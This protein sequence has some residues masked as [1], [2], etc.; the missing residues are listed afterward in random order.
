MI[1][2]TG[3]LINLTEEERKQ[4]YVQVCESLNIDA[5]RRPLAYF[6]QVAPGGKRVLILYTLRGGA[7][8]IATAQNINTTVERYRDGEVDGIVA[9][10]AT[11]THPAGR[12]GQ[13]IGAEDLDR[14]SRADAVM[15]ASTKAI[16]R[17]ILNVT[18]A[19][20]LDETEVQGMSGSTV[21]CEP[22]IG[23]DY[24]PPAPAPVVTAAP[25]KEVVEPP[26]VAVLELKGAD[27][28]VFTDALINPPAPAP[29][30][31]AA[32]QQTDEQAK[33][34]IIM[35]L[36]AY[37]KNTLQEGGM[38]PSKGFGIAAKWLKFLTKHAPNKSIA[39]YQKLIVALDAVMKDKNAVGVVE[40]I[41]RE[42][43]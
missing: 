22:G 28:K 12:V 21:E 6:E 5:R 37:R 18:G 43:A 3:D 16:R 8:Q 33:N 10:R 34:E 26:P 27:A 30:L 13:A 11:A 31:E 1:V 14:E 29:A 4:Y 20:L 38:K 15:T 23:A 24:V 17:A 7:E 39:E 40:Y 42:I 35:R 19:G 25:A 32:V 41:E 36:G 2:V 9:F